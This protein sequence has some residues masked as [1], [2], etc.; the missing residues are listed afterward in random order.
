MMP[1]YCQSTALAT[2]AETAQ[3][4]HGTLLLVCHCTYGLIINGKLLA[5]RTKLYHIIILYQRVGRHYSCKLMGKRCRD[6]ALQIYLHYYIIPTLF[7]Y[8]L[9]CHPYIL[10]HF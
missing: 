5:D 6:E 8:F 9:A 2:V 3:V 1:G 10:L 7:A 4:T